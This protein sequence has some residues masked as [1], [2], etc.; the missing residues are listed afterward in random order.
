MT[1]HGTT[2]NVQRFSTEDGPGIRTTLFMKGC[3]LRC[4]WCHNPEGLSARRELVWYD[5][6]CIGA[7]DCVAACQ[8]GALALE[9]A[10]MR[11]AREV[12]D[13][14]GACVEACPAAALEVIG[15][16]W[17]VEALL[18]EVEKDTLF[19]ETSGGGVTVSGGEPMAQAAFVTELCRQCHKAGLHVALDTCGAASWDRYEAVLPFVDLVLYDLKVHDPARHRAATG[20]DNA[21]ILEN[22]RGIA[23]AGT[24]L[25]IR[26]PVIPGLTG[27]E[28]NVAALAA[29][30]ARELPGVE[31]WD[32]LAYTNLGEPKY[33]R[34]DREYRMKGTPLLTREEM[35]RLHAV[36]VRQ[37]A[38]AVWSGATRD[39]S[40]LQS[41]DK[42]DGDV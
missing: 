25:W 34:L 1:L 16:E 27:D 42:E 35:E 5:T 37:V 21:C 22:A 39:D 6:R 2:F 17:T 4:A 33:A 31:R 38:V 24:R 18:A 9:A 19:Y 8:A 15:R 28:E 40:T 7:R 12:C 41:R 11:I 20:L 32:L 30:V 29:F 10:G 36:A 3:P 26:T 23:A 13:A 14:C